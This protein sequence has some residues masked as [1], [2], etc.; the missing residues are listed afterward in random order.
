MEE[1]FIVHREVSHPVYETSI[2]NLLSGY[3]FTPPF[4]S[5]IYF[6]M[7]DLVSLIVHQNKR[8]DPGHHRIGAIAFLNLRAPAVAVLQLLPSA[9]ILIQHVEI[10]WY[11]NAI[12][13]P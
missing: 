4:D 6:D 8:K 1:Q 10:R 12:Q 11:C 9:T 3:F 2:R 5:P 13:A 7:S